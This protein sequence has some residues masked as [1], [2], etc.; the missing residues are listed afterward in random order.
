MKLRVA[1]DALVLRLAIPAKRLRLAAL[2]VS[3]RLAVPAK[4]LRVAVGEFIAFL[5]PTDTATT[6][7]ASSFSVGKGLADDAAVGP[8]QIQIEFRKAP[9]DRA[10]FDDGNPYFAEDYVVG[11]P[12]FQTYT[13]GIQVAK[14]VGKVSSDSAAVASLPQIFLGRGYADAAMADEASSRAFGKVLGHG[15]GVTD[16]LNGA[17]PLDDQTIAFF[18]SLEYVPVATEATAFLLQRGL[19]DG[20]SASED[21]VLLIAPAYF[22]TPAVA[23]THTLTN[24]KI[25]G[26]TSTTSDTDVLLTGKVLADSAGADSAGSLRS[27]GYTVDLTYFAEDYV[28]ESRTF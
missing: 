6:S 7:E 14:L 24:L 20:S 3:L 22:E 19:A 5:Y 27:Q 21:S 12:V 16:D 17:M 18:K 2:G 10:G 25:L 4:R 8:H 13:L 1:I 11:A 26:H 9:S 28:G 23:A 15:V